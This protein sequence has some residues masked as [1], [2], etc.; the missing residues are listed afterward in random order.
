MNS[1]GREFKI[2]LS[3]QDM[4]SSGILNHCNIVY[5]LVDVKCYAFANHII[6][7]LQVTF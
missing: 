6:N 2:R 4:Q 3:T 1:H 5:I 7:I